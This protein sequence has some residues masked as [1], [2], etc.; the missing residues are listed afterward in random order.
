VARIKKVK[1]TIY[2][3]IQKFASHLGLARYQYM[4]DT[5]TDRRTEL[6]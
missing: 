6:Q 3:K 1:K 2:G 5:K 4:A